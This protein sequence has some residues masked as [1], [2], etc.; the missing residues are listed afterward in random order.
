MDL[1]EEFLEQVI[2]LDRSTIPEFVKLLAQF[3]PERTLKF[4]IPKL[5]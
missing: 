2:Y 4:V 3:N 1:M 5:Y